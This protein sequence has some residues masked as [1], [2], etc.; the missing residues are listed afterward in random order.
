LNG[1]GIQDATSGAWENHAASH[2][3]P[4]GKSLG[5]NVHLDHITKGPYSLRFAASGS[6]ALLADAGFAGKP[7]K[8]I[9]AQSGVLAQGR[10]ASDGSLPRVEA[11]ELK[12][13]TL[14]LGTMKCQLVANTAVSALADGDQNNAAD[15]NESLSEED[16]QSLISSPFYEAPTTDNHNDVDF[17]GT[18]NI[19][20]YFV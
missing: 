4:K 8:V 15:L 1:Q 10:L 13:L 14:L 12:Q 19:R 7:F 18:Q 16:T 3:T 9:D 17:L 6:D 11:N 2:A 20:D 5:L